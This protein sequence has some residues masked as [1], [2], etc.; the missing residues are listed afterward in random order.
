MA[1]CVHCKD[2]TFPQMLLL[3]DR[4]HDA[5]DRIYHAI[6]A[7]QSGEKMLMPVLEPYNTVGSSRYVDF[8]TTRDVYATDAATCHVS[9][10]VL[11]SNWEAKLAQSLEEMDEV[12][13]YVKN[14]GLGF[15]IPYTING[16][17][18]N[19]R[20]DYIVRIDDGHRTASSAPS[21]PAGEGRGE[22]EPMVDPLHLIVEVTGE[23]RK[24]KAAKVRTARTLWVPAIN[25]HGGFG[26]WAF[27]EITDPWD[28]KNTIRAFLRRLKREAGTE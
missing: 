24:D 17:E 26:R 22:G 11:D 13:A 15:A 27:V 8:D 18:R 23:R 14:Q 9:H 19:Y 1:E 4:A 6:V 10:V 25:H 2:N 21:S 16:A 7:T 5:A 12:L 20:P 3:I 28:A